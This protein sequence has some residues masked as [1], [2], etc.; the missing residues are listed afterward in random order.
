MTSAP[1]DLR[2]AYVGG[3][4]RQWARIIMADLALCRI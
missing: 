4:S 3:G 2:I 1:V